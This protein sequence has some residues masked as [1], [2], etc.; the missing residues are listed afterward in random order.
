VPDPRAPLLQGR[1]TRAERIHIQHVV[2]SLRPGGLE[3]GVV[4]VVNSLDPQRFRSSACCLD[5]AG[6]FAERLKPEVEVRVLGRKAGLDL[7]L[8]WRL[9][10]LFRSTRTAVVHT[11]NPEALLYGALAARLARVPGLVYSE[12]GRE[13]PERPRLR[14]AQRLLSRLVDANVA[15][16][17]DLRRLLVDEVGIPRDAVTVVYN[18]VDCERFRPGKR[19]GARQRWGVAPSTIVIGSVGRLVPGKSYET[20]LRAARGLPAKTEIWLIGDGPQRPELE[21]LARGLLPPGRARF[22]GHR[23]DLPEILPAFDVFVLPSLSEGVSNTLLEA[24][25]CGLPPVV[26]RVGGNTEVVQEDLSGLVFAPG[27]ERELARVLLGLCASSERRTTLGMRAAERV[28]CHF[29]LE[30]MVSHYDRIY[31]EVVGRRGRLRG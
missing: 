9:A 8:F 6:S 15:V 25:A 29:S 4:N 1:A 10:R 14:R 5:T 22:L 20:L 18:G 7:G 19:A 26:S 13:T 23:D 11:R 31:T 12:H 24:M 28:R 30:E 3:N 27:D 17:E 21:G 2:L 16:S